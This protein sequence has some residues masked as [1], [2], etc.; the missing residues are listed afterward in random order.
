MPLNGTHTASAPRIYFTPDSSLNFNPPKSLFYNLTSKPIYLTNAF[1]SSIHLTLSAIISSTIL[2]TF[3]ALPYFNPSQSYPHYPPSQQNTPPI[4][5]LH[6]LYPI[7][8]SPTNKERT[9]TTCQPQSQ[10]PSPLLKKCSPPA[11]Y[12]Y[13][14]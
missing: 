1:I 10:P 14:A 13:T 5:N 4:K 11:S 2:N 12:T 6:R 9:P 7:P 8:S 3:S